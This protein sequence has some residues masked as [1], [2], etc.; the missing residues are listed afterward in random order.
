M[1]TADGKQH[2]SLDAGTPVKQNSSRSSAEAYVTVTGP[3]GLFSGYLLVDSGCSLELNLSEHK[4]RQV[5]V[6]DPNETEQVETGSSTWT[7]NL[8][9]ILQA[10]K[11]EIHWALKASNLEPSHGD[12]LK[13]A[14]PWETGCWTV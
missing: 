10:V 8:E 2:V 3:K 5:G 11:D 12:S 7:E 1:Q 14:F 4:A 13:S 9:S 6:W